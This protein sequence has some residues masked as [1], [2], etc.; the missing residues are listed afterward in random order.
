MGINFHSEDNRGSY[1]TREADASWVAAMKELV[2]YQ[3]IAKAADI[4]CGG[5]IYSKALA[6]MG[7]NSVT[8]V[9]FSEAMLKGASEYC[10][11][12]KNIRFHYG[13][14]FAS[15]I[16]ANEL[17]LVLERALIHHIK[18]LRACFQE[19]YRI[20]GNGG[21]YIIQD[22]TPE[23]CLIKGSDSHIRGYFFEK[24]PRLKDI[25]TKRR[26]AAPTVIHALKE[27]GFHNIEQRKLW[28]TRE[29]YSSKTQLLKDV[30]ERTG[31][32]ILHELNEE[33]LTN[34]LQ[35]LDQ[36]ITREETIVEKDR[37]TLWKAVK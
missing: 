20:L 24:L 14:A 8:G 32:S 33:E 16:N 13:T 11:D 28:E 30:E 10:W 34:L 23:D 1:T 9:D 25:E 22:R 12:R 26:H 36:S 37:W 7:A 2:S 5:G 17:Q 31:R 29:I 35:H 6:D 19:A 21:V 27:A 18:D 3:D 4:G 15:G